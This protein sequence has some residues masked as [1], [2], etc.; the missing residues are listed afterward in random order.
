MRNTYHCGDL[1]REIRHGVASPSNLFTG[2]KIYILD[3]LRKVTSEPM[4]G[5]DPRPRRKSV[6][7]IF[8]ESSSFASVTKSTVHKILRSTG[9]TAQRR[10]W[11]DPLMQW[12]GGWVGQASDEV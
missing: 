2:K 7:R 11:S 8:E 1:T 12:S 6:G 3:A 10:I 5:A 4:A 9:P